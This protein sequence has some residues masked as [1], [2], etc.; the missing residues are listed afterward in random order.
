MRITDSMLYTNANSS[1]GAAR[2]AVSTATE[3]TSSGMRVVQPGDDPAATA[4]ILTD[5]AAGKYADAIVK[6]TT[7]A[8]S[9]LAIADG[10]LGTVTS[11]LATASQLAVQ[12]ANDSNNATDRA[13]AA[14]NV[15]AL[16]Q[17][18]IAAL[19]TKS[20][21]RYLFGGSQDQSSPFDAA[22]NYAG[23]SQVRTIEVAPGV[24]QAASVRA[25]V[26]IKGVGGGVDVIA[27]LNALQ[28]ALA[29]N[30][31]TTIQNSID[32]LKAATNQVSLLRTQAGANENALA[33]AESV[34]QA[35]SNSE[36][37][38]VSNLQDA[39]IVAT[40]TKLQMAQTALQAA[41][42]ASTQSFKFTLLNPN[43]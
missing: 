24:Q 8:Q 22:G 3:Q 26:G 34:A 21:D 28:T 4:S 17:Q 23:D 10:A 20:G 32:A 2:T 40:A 9:E 39:D 29:N 27:T 25:D 15:Q 12:F 13:N 36:T 31:T 43:G 11:S 41:I 7:A 18:I 30:D 5:T 33:A 38:Q 35:T 37:K 19:N 14:P 42:S 16:I 1:I 6:S